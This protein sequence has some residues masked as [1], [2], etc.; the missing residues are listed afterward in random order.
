MSLL[1]S[2]LLIGFTGS[3]HCVGMCGPLAMALPVKEGEKKGFRIFQYLV[4]K[5]ITYSI[6][7]GLFGL[8]GSQLILA[9]WQQAVSIVLGCLLLG[10]TFCLLFKKSWFHQGFVANW[11]SEKLNP[12]FVKLF[13]S[14]SPFT[15]VAFGM[16]NGLLPCGLV[17]MGI[18]GAIST[19]SFANGMLFMALFGIGTMPVMLSFLL[20]AKQFS[21]TFKRV[22]QKATPYL[23]MAMAA[24][25]ILRGLGLSIPFVSPDLSEV[26]FIEKSGTKIVCHP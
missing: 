6:L 15:A 5:T 10:V 2:A 7:G 16:L 8:F 26:L 3:F 14:D 19:S 9:G 23:M 4:G 25:L 24:M 13:N 12:L 11:I 22:I 1:F 17:Y 18:I 21:F 20:M